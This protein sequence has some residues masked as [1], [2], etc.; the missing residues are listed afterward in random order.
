MNT[1]LAVLTGGGI[2]AAGGL[3]GGWWDNRQGAKRDARAHKNQE[4]MARDDRAHQLELV[5]EEH[6]SQERMAR[7]AL[8]QE[9]LERTYTE[10]GIYLSHH[11]DW[12][13]TIQPMMGEPKPPDP[14]PRN[15]QWR[16]E[17]LLMNHASPE[18][19]QLLET[20]RKWPEKI[21]I[22]VI[23]INTARGIASPAFTRKLTTSRPRLP[24]TGRRCRKPTAPSATRCTASYTPT[25]P[26]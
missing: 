21:Q 23:T 10:I 8:R 26:P 24:D 17:A 1:L 4:L 16:F 14:V 11:A 6:A 7:E 19:R 12:A 22:A 15:E 20:W 9:R 2:T 3:V 18:V 13:G 25:L 5:R